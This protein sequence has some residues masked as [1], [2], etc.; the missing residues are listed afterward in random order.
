MKK[1]ILDSPTLSKLFKMSTYPDELFIFLTTRCNIRCLIC[2]REDH[3]PIDLDFENIQKLTD[4]IKHAKIIDLTGWGEPFLYKNMDKVIDFIAKNNKKSDVIRITT[5][6]TLLNE[7]Y[8]KLLNNKLSNLTISL[9]AATKDTYNRDMQYSDFDTVIANIKNFI[10]V[11]NHHTIAKIDF[12]FVA[13]LE[14]YKEIPEFVVLA[15]ALGVKSVSIGNY[16]ISTDDHLH[17]S[18]L[19]EKNKYNEVVESAEKIASAKG[20]YFSARKFFVDDAQ[21]IFT[22]KCFFPYTQFFVQP[23]GEV[24]GPCCYAGS[25]PLGNVYR[26]GFETV[27]LSE[28]YK[29]LRERRHLPACQACTVY[30]PF[31]SLGTHF[32][33]AFLRKNRE[34]IE[35]FFSGDEK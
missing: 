11:L 15:D 9:N 24:S 23:D 12:H 32:E 8:G 29:K 19:H 14:N 1:I 27:W 30:S 17:L 4:P 6:G 18:L 5:N 3:N 33:S 21:E 16:I 28:K 2:R 13:H 10:S 7:K 35:K 20:I 31:D 26:D 25:Y 34:K 22:N